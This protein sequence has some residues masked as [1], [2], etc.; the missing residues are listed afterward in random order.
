[1]RDWT[2]SPTTLLT[3]QV[4][5]PDTF[6]IYHVTLLCEIFEFSFVVSDVL[7]DS[8]SP[9]LYYR[10]RAFLE[11]F[12]QELILE[13]V[14]VLSSFFLTIYCFETMLFF[15]LCLGPSKCHYIRQW[16]V[17]YFLLRLLS[18]ECNIQTQTRVLDYYLFAPRFSLYSLTA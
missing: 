18:F 16:F 12:T 3:R 9:K 15:H 5:M 17:L 6:M 1:M 13:T 11:L 2:G 7:S 8:E 4:V 14:E 10:L